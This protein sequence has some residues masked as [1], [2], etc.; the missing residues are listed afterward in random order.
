MKICTNFELLNVY[1]ILTFQKPYIKTVFAFFLYFFVETSN[2]SLQFLGHLYAVS[3]FQYPIIT[4][5][6][7]CEQLRN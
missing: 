2:Q 5:T 7:K 6:F 3:T 1:S 4:L